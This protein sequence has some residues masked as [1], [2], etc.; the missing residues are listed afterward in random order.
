MAV[1]TKINK[2]DISIKQTIYS[3]IEIYFRNNVSVKNI[4]LMDAY[5]YFLK[6]INDTKKFNLDEEI[7][8]MEFEDRILNG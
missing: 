6:K 2:K 5:K 1:Y 3:L 7:L 8:F 4:K